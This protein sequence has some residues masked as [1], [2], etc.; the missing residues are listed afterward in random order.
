MRKISIAR[1][2]HPESLELAALRAFADG[3]IAEAFRNIDRRCRVPPLARAHHYVLRAEALSRMGDGR[4]AMADIVRALELAPENIQANRRMLA[5]GNGRVQLD[6]ARMLI[7]RD[8]D[9]VVLIDALD[10]LRQAGSRALA[11]VRIFDDV[12]AGWVAWDENG[13][14]ELTISGLGEHTIEILPEEDHPLRRSKFANVAS[15]QLDRSRSS[16]AEIVSLSCDNE[17]F[18]SVRTPANNRL[19]PSVAPVSDISS[20]SNSI[21]IIVPIYRDFEATRKCLESLRLAM[22]D[23]TD[24]RAILIDDAS[25]EPKIKSYLTKFSDLSNFKVLSNATNMGFVGAVNRALEL[26]STGDIILLN[27]DTVVPHGFIQRLTATARSDPAIGTITP[28]SNN[29]E[30][31]SFPLANEPN[32]I[33]SAAGISEIDAIA[34]RINLGKV[35]DI[36]SGIGFCLYITRRCLDRVGLLSEAYYRGYLEDVDFCLRARE[37]GFRNVCD[38]SVYIGHAGSRS[39][40][41]EKRALVVQ[42]LDALQI[43]YPDHGGECAAFVAADPLS[44]SRERIERRLS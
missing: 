22:A 25:P 21:T 35:V 20:E 41:K 2:P 9:L 27:A 38:P 19:V 10:V 13:V 15:I 7:A 32:P 43:K 24:C 42:N 18:Y 39:F 44:E 4:G 17:I 30:F 28:L 11:C 40:G 1:D 31:T 37:H 3:H 8:P 16:V 6:A 33:P 26:L 5:W 36:P 23:V 12:I 14:I 29:G 34:A